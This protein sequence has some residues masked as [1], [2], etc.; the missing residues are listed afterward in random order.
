MYRVANQ[1]R[2]DSMEVNVD[3]VHLLW[4]P[5]HVHGVYH[6]IHSCWILVRL[7][8]SSFPEGM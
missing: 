7:L 1:C 6:H 2:A 8:A 4:L 3:V 5:F